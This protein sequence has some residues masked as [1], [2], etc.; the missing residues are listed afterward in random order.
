MVLGFSEIKYSMH[1]LDNIRKIQIK[2]I[3]Y[4]YQVLDR[5]FF[6]TFIEPSVCF[7]DSLENAIK[8]VREKYKNGRIALIE[9]KSDFLSEDDRRF[10]RES[11]KDLLYKN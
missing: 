9:E 8:I 10:I 3:N 4:S 7:E 5:T 6:P 1:R 2:Q 11:L